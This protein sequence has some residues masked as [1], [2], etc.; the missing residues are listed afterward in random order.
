MT[1]PITAPARIRSLT[2]PEH[3]KGRLYTAH[4]LVAARDEW[5]RQNWNPCAVGKIASELG[6]TLRQVYKIARR[7]GLT[8]RQPA[9]DNFR[10]R[11]LR[12]G[13]V[14][15]AVLSMPSAAQDALERRCAKT[16][17]SL[18]EAMAAAWAEAN[19]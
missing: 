16:G 9:R 4:D 2:A 13:I 6:I 17:E 15:K 1:A 12:L 3:I 14:S 7:L 18:A 10:N 19:Q 5:L 8:V 11:G